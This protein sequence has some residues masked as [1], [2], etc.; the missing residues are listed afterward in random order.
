[1]NLK[2]TDLHNPITGSQIK[3]GGKTHKQLV[4][5]EVL[6]DNGTVKASKAAIATEKERL[7]KV[8]AE[9]AQRRKLLVHGSVEERIDLALADIK[10]VEQA[11]LI[12][13]RV[14]AY[15][16]TKFASSIKSLSE[17]VGALKL[18]GDPPHSP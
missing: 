9:R 3:M 4:K 10:T 16:K 13:A 8:A 11:M 14:C 6:D 18:S 5:S 12:V 7:A 17:V 1:M 15:V 2:M